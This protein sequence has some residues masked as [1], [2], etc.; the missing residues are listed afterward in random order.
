MERLK[1]YED[2]E[3]TPEDDCSRAVRKSELPAR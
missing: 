1:A 3:L 2:T